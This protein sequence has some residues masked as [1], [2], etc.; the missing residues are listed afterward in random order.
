MAITDE[1]RRGAQEVFYLPR[2]G[3]LGEFEKTEEEIEFDKFR[4]EMKD[5]ISY[6]K[7]N[8]Y[9]QPVGFG[10]RGST[11]KLTFL[12]EAGF[13]EYTYSQMASKLL[14][15]YGTGTYRLQARDDKNILRMNRAINVEAPKKDLVS[16][17][18]NDM[19]GIMREMRE[20]MSQQMDT[21]QNLMQ[22]SG[23]LSDP[24]DQMT[25]M[26]AAMG[27]MMGA[28]GIN[29]APVVPKTLLE[30][31][32]EFQMLKELMG[33][34]NDSGDGNIYGLLTETVKNIGPL[35]GAAVAAGQK[36]GSINEQGKIEAPKSEPEPMTTEQ[37]EL[38]AIK[39]QMIFLLNQAKLG[40]EPFDVAQFV[41]KNIPD[42]QME[43][44]EEFLSQEN[45][46]EKGISVVPELAEYQSWLEKWRDAMLNGLAQILDGGE[47]VI[48]SDETPDDPP[49]KPDLT[50][51][52]KTPN[53]AADSEAGN[54]DGLK[55][56]ASGSGTETASD[57]ESD[58]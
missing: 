19:T 54:A 43:D 7:I 45:C 31:M 15:E 27:A 21:L 39:P 18:Q 28:M 12:F 25:K 11:K 57:T 16:G 13:D 49:E 26:M 14:D 44:V 24:I 48:E 50:D 1:E 32:T 37:Q 22:P 46:L 10:G 53:N 4:E 40:A 23:S 41:I 30:Q 5:G 55:D 38:E 6:A 9:R 47:D 29:T 36:D 51:S 3:E 33:N 34:D 17:A 20:A 42:E 2:E 56:I 8:V 52:E 58:T 35:L